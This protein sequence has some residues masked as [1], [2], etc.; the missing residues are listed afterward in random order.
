MKLRLAT[1]GLA[2]GLALG[3]ARTLSAD[4]M[5]ARFD[6]LGD[7]YLD[8]W[9]ARHPQLATRLGEHQWDGR[10]VPVTEASVASDVQWLEAMRTRLRAIP[11]SALSFER[12]QE[13]D[14]LAARI[15]REIIDLDEVRSWE[16]DP[17]YYLDLVAGSV[18]SVLERGFASPCERL[19][20][21]TRRLK[22]VPEVLRA[23][24]VNLKRP[25]RLATEIAITQYT[26]VLDFYRTTVPSL[27]G[28]CREPLLHAD[29]AEADSQAVRAVEEFLQVLRAEVL[30]KST[31]DFALGQDLVQRRLAAAELEEA[32]VD[33]LLAAG[34]T[35]LDETR[36]RMAEVAERIAPG[37]GTRAALDSIRRDAPGA[38]ALVPFVESRLDT[39]RAFLRAHSILTL[40]AAE[41]LTVRETPPF[42]RSLSFASMDAPGVWERRATR[43]YLNVTPIDPAWSG[44]ER[45]DHLAFFNRAAA[46]IV[47]IHEALPGHYYQFLALQRVPARLRQALRS[48]AY[49]EGWAHYCEQMMLEE[50]YG[51]GDPAIELAQ[52]DLALQRIGRLIASLS[53]QTGRMSLAD[54]SR[55]FEERCNMAPVNAAR[56]ARRAAVDLDDLAY[57]LGKW[58]ILGLRNEAQRMLGPAFRLREFHDVLLAQ[59]AVPLRLAREGVLR[60]LGSRHH[61]TAG[62]DR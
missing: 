25:P 47:A 59:G 11:L 32:P 51:A 23:A 20:L 35:A 15:E 46:E 50:G 45:L 22:A 30:P 6:K 41:D 49:T 40:P 48:T 13:H 34:W 31:E 3:S 5:D 1:L 18:L 19:Q 39:I 14:L 28:E 58:R 55:L 26:G 7:E 21:A 57:T 9:L 16:R 27:S 2:L 17:S 33:S 24:S 4:P 43:A 10:L 29:L 12:A 36:A 60:E 61:T 52:L 62:G 56:E 42:R 37:L 54:A 44:Q 38:G 8:G 53:L